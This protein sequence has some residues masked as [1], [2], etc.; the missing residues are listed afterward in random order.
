MKTPESDIET[1][2]LCSTSIHDISLNC[3]P[4]PVYEKSK[5]FA[6]SRTNDCMAESVTSTLE[7]MSKKISSPFEEQ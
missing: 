3:R 5:F 2:S 1:S 6:A 4:K 7:Y